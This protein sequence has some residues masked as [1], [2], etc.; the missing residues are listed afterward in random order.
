M[1]ERERVLQLKPHLL[2]WNAYFTGMISILRIARKDRRKMR[3]GW[4]GGEGLGS[5]RL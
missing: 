2:V 1:K 3:A 4:G 5:R